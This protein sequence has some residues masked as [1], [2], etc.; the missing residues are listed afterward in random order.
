MKCNL[1]NF[2]TLLH[3]RDAEIMPS[4]WR[5]GRKPFCRLFARYSSQKIGQWIWPEPVLYLAMSN[6]QGPWSHQCVSINLFALLSRL[7]VP[8]KLVFS[9]ADPRNVIAVKVMVK[10]KSLFRLKDGLWLCFVDANT[11]QHLPL[12]GK[13]L[14]KICHLYSGS[15]PIKASKGE[16]VEVK[17]T[18][19]IPLL[20]KD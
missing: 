19:L 7:S 8:L 12:H 17:R 3:W 4:R 11:T 1:P 9:S 13:F 14:Q 6:P 18:L 20:W 5:T 15:E 16:G 2:F 10:S